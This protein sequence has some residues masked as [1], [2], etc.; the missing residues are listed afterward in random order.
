MIPVLSAIVPVLLL[1]ATGWVLCNRGIVPKDRWS[2]MED[3]A[4]WVLFPSII[5]VNVGT[6]DFSKMPV[7]ELTVGVLGV[8]L[9]LVAVS[10]ALR[11]WMANRLSING[12]RFTSIFQGIVRWNGFMALT[13][14][15]EL[16]GEDG[17]TLVAVVMAAMIPAANLMCVTVLSLYAGGSVPSPKALAKQLLK[18]PFIIVVA[19]G[20]LFNASDIPLPDML[21]NYLKFL[22]SAALPIGILSVGAALDLSALRRPGPALTSS[23]LLRNMFAP[24][25]AIAMAFALQLDA[26]AGTILVLVFAVPSA[27]AS[28]VLAKKMGGDAKLMAEILTLQTVV[29]ALTVPGWLLA[30]TYVIG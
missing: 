20:A 7:I 14:A 25:S 5:F 9:F 11:P 13:I 17:V 1:I 29:S 18:N 12:T 21:F 6:S 19:S 27:G 8:F 15:A 2:G 24:L 22:G 10:L 26:T 23:L 30:A 16:F 28:Y 3:L 4:Y